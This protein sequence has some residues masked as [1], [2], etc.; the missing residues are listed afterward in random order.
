[1]TS[2][3]Q[4]Q[5]A[6]AGYIRDPAGQPM[7]ADLPP[8]RMAMYREL[9]YNNVESFLRGNFPVLCS[10]FGEAAWHALAE[11]FFA[12]HP[13]RTPYF[14]AIPEEFLAYLREERG[15]VAG[16]P[17]FMA[18]LA[19][20][21]WA[22]MAVGI[23]QAEPPPPLEGEPLEQALLLSPLAWLLAYPWP[24]HKI[25][26][27]YQPQQPDA[28]PTLL[29]IC[30]NRQEQVKF[31]EI[32]PLTYRLLE[33]LQ[34]EPGQTGASYLQQ[35]AGEWGSLPLEAVLRGGAEILQGLAARDV[36]GRAT[37]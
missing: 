16:D 13:C 22:E 18:A 21:E 37:R 28:A 35:I 20:Y 25:G 4:I 24:V 14:Y 12:R 8:R 5:Q 1:M 6:F 2:L 26:P 30:R 3:A 23:A 34:A 9:F 27:D 32:N 15:E 17:P 10:L 31:M 7:P 36:I 19:H 29:V 33:L 11:D